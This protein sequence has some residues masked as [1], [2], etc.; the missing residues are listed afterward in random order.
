MR[1]TNPLCLLPLLLGCL[2]LLSSCAPP[3]SYPRSQ[4]ADMSQDRA[5]QNT[6]DIKQKL[7]RQQQEIETL[8]QKVAK[9]RQEAT[10]QKQTLTQLQK[11]I[12]QKQQKGQQQAPTKALKS[13]TAT[14]PAQEQKESLSGSKTNAMAARKLYR[15][16]FNAQAQG[17]YQQAAKEYGAFVQQHPDHHFAAQAMFRRGEMLEL[18]QQLDKARQAYQ[19]LVTQYPQSPQAPEALAT[20]ARLLKKAGRTSAA[21]NAW[22]Q[23]QRQ[24]P[25][26]AAA[27]NSRHP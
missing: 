26:S 22:R 4:P 7:K 13:Q 10:S 16:A 20:M 17:Q 19:S 5:T 25:D 12:K 8:Q 27:Q 23:L 1:F 6:T 9:L 11:T 24:Y 14:P 3:G 2:W 18:T 21:R 15:Q